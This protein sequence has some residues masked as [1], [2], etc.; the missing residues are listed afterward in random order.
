MNTALEFDDQPVSAIALEHPSAI[1]V[2]TK[3]N[4]D[5]CCGGKLP[6]KEAC[7]KSSVSLDAVLNELNQTETSGMP[8]TIRFDTWDV[9]FLADFII[10]HHHQFIKR[11]IPQ[12]KELLTKVCSVHGD[13]HPYLFTIKQTFE[14]LAEELLLHMHKEEV[15]LFPEVKR[16]FAGNAPPA[17]DV[18]APMAV[19]QDEHEH[20]GKL[21]KHIRNLTTRYSPPADACPTFRITYKQL[22]KFDQ[23]LMQHIHLENNVLFER[24]REKI[25]TI[26]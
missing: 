19:M 2:F 6:L 8:G 24:V 3:Y 10:Q 26:F 1:A 13:R 17:I 23:D 16:I 7:A 11:S 14:E 18:T 15:I 12:L 22:Q 4:I 25:T 20:A 21:I 9:P 5:F